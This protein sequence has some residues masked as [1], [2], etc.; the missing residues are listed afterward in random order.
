MTF[1]QIGE[2]FP[3]FKD[4][5]KYDNAEKCVEKMEKDKQLIK[6]FKEA[7]SKPEW[8]NRL[9][10]EQ[11]LNCGIKVLNK[12]KPEKKEKAKKIKKIVRTASKRL[13]KPQVKK[14]APHQKGLNSPS[15]KEKTKALTDLL[16]TIQSFTAAPILT[17]PQVQELEL[18]MKN[19]LKITPKDLLTNFNS[20]H[21]A[22]T[23]DTV[24]LT[25]IKCLKN[26]IK[27]APQPLKSAFLT[28]DSIVR[29]FE[30][31]WAQASSIQ[32][33]MSASEAL[34]IALIA[35]YEIPKIKEIVKK[36]FSD[37]ST[38]KL[39]L[40]GSDIIP[41]FEKK[42]IYVISNH[43]L[44]QGG[45]KTAFTAVQFDYAS[46][47]GKLS[48]PKIVVSLKT[49]EAA[50]TAT[51][52]AIE[53]EIAI[54]TALKGDSLFI[55]A[56]NAHRI[57][58]N[59]KHTMNMV[60]EKCDADLHTII[61]A[62]KPYGLTLQEKLQVAKDIVSSV[63]TLHKKGYIHGDIKPGN[64]LMKAKKVKLADF[65][66]STSIK[67]ALQKSPYMIRDGHYGTLMYTAPEL[68]D[69]M[70]V[71]T[72]SLRKVEIYPVGITLWLLFAEANIPC[73]D[74][75]MSVINDSVYNKVPGKNPLQAI[76]RGYIHHQLH[77]ISQRPMI[78]G[79]AATAFNKSISI[80][81]RMMLPV[82][83]RLGL[84]QALAELNQIHIV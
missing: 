43:I 17:Q 70:V 40:D 66:T 76:T 44:G 56:L 84:D 47:Q 73:Y 1:L 61:F 45:F 81:L 63:I 53:N 29:C 71:S 12:K 42:K 67:K 16:S 60:V 68:L 18:R 49:P 57:S 10:I 74:E 31:I 69:Q 8:E 39:L 25:I 27:E 36:V 80:A 9:K 59:G 15:K 37:K 51:K 64:F 82:D 35:K 6:F 79:A 7:L 55:K 34:H 32:N 78:P 48:E 23:P 20:N 77:D 41:N 26:A 83:E 4:Y 72:D 24:T 38:K 62:K 19:T 22:K 2:Y 58:V 30:N 21:L 13:E 50:G 5:F 54:T 52:E 33:T 46:D 28:F 3:K 11:L 75:I 14:K 65:G